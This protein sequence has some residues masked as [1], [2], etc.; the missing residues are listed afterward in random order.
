MESV[1]ERSQK[2]K[3]ET[4]QKEPSTRFPCVYNRNN[5]PPER[6]ESTK[7]GRSVNRGREAWPQREGRQRSRAG[8]IYICMYC[9]M[10]D[11]GP[12]D[13]RGIMS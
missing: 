12:W 8:C 5:R 10:Q 9:W 3:R 6:P 2:Q 13:L 1:A 11:A 4:A 7:R